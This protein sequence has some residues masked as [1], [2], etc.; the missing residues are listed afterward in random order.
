MA[1]IY[2]VASIAPLW[3]WGDYLRARMASHRE[4]IG[5]RTKICVYASNIGPKKLILTTLKIT[6]LSNGFQGLIPRE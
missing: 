3:A 1:A 2:M 5:L 6:I 4:R